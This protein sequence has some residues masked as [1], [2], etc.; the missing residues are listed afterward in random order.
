MMY[1]LMYARMCMWEGCL[2]MWVQAFTHLC[3]EDYLGPCHLP[4][5]RQGSL[6]LQLSTQGWLDGEI[7]GVLLS[8]LSIYHRALELQ[9]C[10]TVPSS[11]V[12]LGDLNSDLHACTRNILLS[13]LPSP[14]PFENQCME[15]KITYCITHNNKS[16]MNLQM[17]E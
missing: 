5:L 11:Y 17:Q 1:V 12:M 7:P 4:R 2:C 6:F 10:A 8:L 9:M 15:W 14:Y 16:M 3:L 13:Y